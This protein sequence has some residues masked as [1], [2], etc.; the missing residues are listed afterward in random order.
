MP[1]NPATLLEQ[2]VQ[3]LRTGAEP[4]HDP[5]EESPSRPQTADPQADVLETAMAELR[6][7]LRPGVASREGADTQRQTPGSTPAGVT[8]PAIAERT[9]VLD[10]IARQNNIDAQTL[11]DALIGEMTGRTNPAAE[12]V[13]DVAQ[14]RPSVIEL[15]RQGE[16]PNQK[17]SIL[18]QLLQEAT[19]VTEE[20]SPDDKAEFD[21][22]LRQMMQGDDA[23]KEEREAAFQ[24]R[25]PDVQVETQ[26]DGV[27]SFSDQG[28]G[29]QTR[30]E[31]ERKA[32]REVQSETETIPAGQSIVVGEGREVTA[33]AAHT[34][35]IARTRRTDKDQ[36]MFG[37]QKSGA[38]SQIQERLS[39][40][41]NIDDPDE[42]FNAMQRMAPEIAAYGNQRRSEI[43]NEVFSEF[44]VDR[45]ERDLAVQER[46]DRE[47]P[48]WDEFRRD[49]PHTANLRQQ[50]RVAKQDAMGEIN[51]RLESD[52]M[53][54][55]LEAQTGMVEAMVER[56]D[57]QDT[58][59]TLADHWDTLAP[60][61]R[62]RVQTA[63]QAQHPDVDFANETSE[64]LAKLYSGDEEFYNAVAAMDSPAETIGALVNDADNA[65]KWRNYLINAEKA[66]GADDQ[67]AQQ[68]AGQ[69]TQ[70]AN[71]TNELLST[72]WQQEDVSDQPEKLQGILD[73]WSTESDQLSPTE[74]NQ[75]KQSYY[76]P[77]LVE[78]QMQ[79]RQREQASVADMEITNHQPQSGDGTVDEVLRQANERGFSLGDL[80]NPSKLATLESADAQSS[81][82]FGG[83]MD[84]GTA[85]ERTLGFLDDESSRRALAQYIA[86][87]RQEKMFTTAMLE[88]IDTTEEVQARLAQARV[89]R[90]SGVH[91]PSTQTGDE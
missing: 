35:N 18:D 12:E 65:N 63:M 74:L 80:M 38:A 47:D 44:D 86:R 15:D 91:R 31:R 21:S 70:I 90:S 68:L 46:R 57:A 29:L 43:R 10:R 79:M 53:L 85:S 62:K 81:P 84:M 51:N 76:V 41:A 49:S 27:M 36:Q 7:A 45:M 37:P 22:K 82:T 64:N 17:E 87:R 20:G 58:Q 5:E 89:S 11:G 8:D 75:R 72:D 88:P 30:N 6:T 40:I 67:T 73:Q 77:R 60:A 69:Y 78:A 14:V 3:R 66:Q 59:F 19:K 61:D 83:I 54:T 55:S 50:L 26:E 1:T 9:G 4:S 34:Q 39:G 24:L 16:V 13:E 71:K 56:R 23:S 42:R 25:H 48:R 32:V 28:P 2:M 52:P 33:L